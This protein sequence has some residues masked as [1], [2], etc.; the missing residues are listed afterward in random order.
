[1][2]KCKRR[3]QLQ[4]END[5][6]CALTTIKPNFDELVQQVQGQVFAENLKK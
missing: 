3:N 2:V 6:R 1:M 5:F 4:P